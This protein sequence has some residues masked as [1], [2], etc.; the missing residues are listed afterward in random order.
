[1][2]QS[3]QQTIAANT[4]KGIDIVPVAQVEQQALKK[5]LT[6]EQAT[7]VADDYGDAQLDALRIS[8]GAVAAAALISLWFTRGLPRSTVAPAAA[9]ETARATAPS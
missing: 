7:A 3:V 6:E 2:P 9:Q 5:G 4:E 8:L 1:M